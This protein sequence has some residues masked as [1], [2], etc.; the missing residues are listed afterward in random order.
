M[1]KETLVNHLAELPALYQEWQG[2]KNCWDTDWL[3]GEELAEYKRLEEIESD[4]DQQVK[5]AGDTVIRVSP[6]Y[7][8]EYQ[9]ILARLA[10]LKP[11]IKR[12]EAIE[13]ALVNLDRMIFP[14]VMGV[15]GLFGSPSVEKVEY[16]ELSNAKDRKEF[17][18]SKVTKI[19][20][21]TYEV[22]EAEVKKV[23]AQTRERLETQYA[24]SLKRLAE[25]KRLARSRQREKLQ[26]INARIRELLNTVIGLSNKELI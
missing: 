1:K 22:Y 10:E 21:A 26:P 14:Q 5:E 2:Y 12:E 9:A 15:R 11:S 8:K 23:K 16:R 3:V 17:A 19:R 20:H 25:L 24:D 13:S 6:D 18:N 7:P 4:I